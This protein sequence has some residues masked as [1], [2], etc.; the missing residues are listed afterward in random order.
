MSRMLGHN[1]MLYECD[2][3]YTA[4]KHPIENYTNTQKKKI[5][6]LSEKKQSVQQYIF[7]YF[8][9]KKMNIQ[10]LFIVPT[11]HQAPSGHWRIRSKQKVCLLEACILGEVTSK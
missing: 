8:I 3:E 1:Q 11:I 7:I 6:I 9:H 5:N 4:I 10:D 2:K